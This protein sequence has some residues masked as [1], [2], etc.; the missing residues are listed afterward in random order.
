MASSGGSPGASLAG[1]IAT[2]THG[3]EFAD[4]LLVDTVRAIHLVGPGGQQW[5]I[6]GGKAVADPA[7]LRARYPRLAED[8][9]IAGGWRQDGLVPQDV[10]AAAVVSLGAF[11]VVYSVV[12]EVQPQYGIKQTVQKTSWAAVLRQANLAADDL[13]RGGAE[14]NMKVLDVILDGTKNGTGIAR[15]DNRYADLA[16]N[17][18]NGDAWITNRQRMPGIPVDV[19]GSSPS[20]LDYINDI[21]AALE[22]GSR[23]K[24]GIF[25]SLLVGRILDFLGLPRD[26][27][28]MACDDQ[29]EIQ[30]LLSWI[31]NWKGGGLSPILAAVAAQA[32]APRSGDIEADFRFRFIAD[33]LSAILNAVQGMSG[34][35]TKTTIANISYRLGAIGWPDGGVAG[36][37]VEIALDPTKAF[38]F[39]QTQLLGGDFFQAMCSPPTD[40]PPDPPFDPLLGYFSVR[41]CP[42][43]QTLMGMQQFG[44]QSVMIEI[45]G[46][47]TPNSRDAMRQ[48]QRT[49]ADLNARTGLKAMLHWGLQNSE[50]TPGALANTP[51][52]DPVGGVGPNAADTKLQR[53]RRVRT[54]LAGGG[55]SPFE[56]AF[57]TQLGL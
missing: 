23:R 11:G 15:N 29:K 17:P 9:I 34:T 42:P 25:Q 41:V 2:A 43:T 24:D 13:V 27:I 19:Q 32:N 1:T 40:P 5:W 55:A 22:R 8:H 7:K 12:L 10:L 37:A 45:V 6:E 33:F 20:P 26:S 38:T 4:P 16:I 44:P 31:G 48:L 18:L 49:V 30:A 39:L 56:N 53:F 47:R 46:F 14:A 28:H 35:Q 50:L 52:G 57:V 54:L 36:T 21:A 3:G 51:L